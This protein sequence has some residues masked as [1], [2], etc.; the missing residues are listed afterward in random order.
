MKKNENK[1]LKTSDQRHVYII[2][3]AKRSGTNTNDGNKND[4][5]LFCMHVEEAVDH[6]RDNKKH[7]E[8]ISKTCLY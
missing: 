1:L 4:W 6:V 3:S 2:L 5:L 8:S 7:V